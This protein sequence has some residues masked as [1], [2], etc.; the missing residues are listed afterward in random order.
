MYRVEKSRAFGTTDRDIKWW[1]GTTFDTTPILDLRHRL[2][3]V[4]VQGRFGNI[5]HP[6]IFPPDLK[7]R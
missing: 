4:T 3:T 1:S 6:V 5:S 7:F 2:G